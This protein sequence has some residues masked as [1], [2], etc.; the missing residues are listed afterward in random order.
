VQSGCRDLHTNHRVSIARCGDIEY[1]GHLT[2]HNDL[3]TNSTDDRRRSWQVPFVPLVAMVFGLLWQPVTAHAE[4]PPVLTPAQQLALARVY[5]PTLV[6]HP[7]EQYFPTNPRPSSVDEVLAAWSSRVDHYRALAPGDKLRRAA[8]AY[9][10][11]TRVEDRHPEVVIEYWCYYV[12]NTYTVRGGWFPYRVHDDHQHDLE[13][14]YLVLRPVGAWSDGA[15]EQWARDAFRLSSIVANAHDGSIAPNQYHAKSGDAVA[16]P[17]H[18]MVERGSHAMAPD[19]DGDGRF[20]PGVDSDNVLKAQ[21]GI[22]DTGSTWRW[23]SV[24][25]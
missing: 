19:I 14:L 13:R 22:R 20:T 8:L 21:W 12:Y 3:L 1:S 4:P 9:R 15:D 25:S 7:Q 16:V 23:Y 10:V 6:F 18:V 24:R 5:A 11:F 17:V 2:R